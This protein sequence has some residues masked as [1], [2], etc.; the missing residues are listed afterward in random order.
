MRF[1]CPRQN[2]ARP[3]GGRP[4]GLQKIA[5]RFRHR[6]YLLFLGEFD[7]ATILWH[8]LFLFPMDIF[9]ITKNLHSP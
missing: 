7:E 5:S 2:C 6:D 1:P 4:R 9:Y 3:Q 8:K